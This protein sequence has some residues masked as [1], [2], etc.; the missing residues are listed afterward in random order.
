MFWQLIMYRTGYVFLLRFWRED[1]QLYCCWGLRVFALRRFWFTVLAN[2]VVQRRMGNLPLLIS[3][4]FLSAW[5]FW[6]LAV[7]YLDSDCLMCWQVSYSKVYDS[8]NEAYAFC[9]CLM[10][11]DLHSWIW[12]SMQINYERLAQQESVSFAQEGSSV[13]FRQRHLSNGMSRVLRLLFYCYGHFG[14]LLLFIRRW[15]GHRLNSCI[16]DKLFVSSKFLH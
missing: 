5:T 7:S 14:R 13:L 10:V 11:L 4:S 15:F 1:R 8:S 2:I 9:W 16:A 12:I 3:S 6:F